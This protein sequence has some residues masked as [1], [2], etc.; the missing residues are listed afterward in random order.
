MFRRFI[1][2]ISAASTGLIA[3]AVREDVHL[4]VQQPLGILQIEQ[5]RRD[6]EPPLVRL[7]DERAV[8]LR[9]HVHRTA[10]DVD[11]DDVGLLI[12]VAVDGRAG[13]L[14]RLQIPDARAGD[15]YSRS[16]ERRGCLRF[17]QRHR[18]VEVVDSCP[19][20]VPPS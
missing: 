11:L 8:H 12:G 4:L 3:H 13:F 2:A 14:C 16:I 5:V 19:E 20:H 18:L 6:P 7:L 17:A 1:S 15:E 9:R 10:G